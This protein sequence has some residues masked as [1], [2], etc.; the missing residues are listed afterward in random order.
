MRALVIEVEGGSA[1]ET[2]LA[3]AGIPELV[4]FAEI[5]VPKGLGRDVGC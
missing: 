3:A 1:K 4:P 2:D 5:L